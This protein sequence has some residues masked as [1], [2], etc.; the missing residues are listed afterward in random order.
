MELSKKKMGKVA[1]PYRTDTAGKLERA[2]MACA[3]AGAAVA[4]FAEV[5]RSRRAGIAG[6]ALMLAGSM[7]GRWMV[8]KAGF[9]SAAAPQYTVEPQRERRDAEQGRP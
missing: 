7:L 5:R 9:Q 8:F 4:V 6:S 1:E 2:T 3:G